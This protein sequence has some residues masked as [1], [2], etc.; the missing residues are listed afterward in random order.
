MLL[1]LATLAAAHTPDPTA[2]GLAGVP[3]TPEAAKPT[4]THKERMAAIRAGERP[5]MLVPFHYEDRGR[6]G[7]GALWH[8]GHGNVWTYAEVRAI[9]A[10]DPASATVAKRSQGLVWGGAAMGL[11]GVTTELVVI[12]LAPVVAP[13]V[14]AADLLLEG[15]GVT[16]EIIGM[17]QTY[18]VVKEYNLAHATPPEPV[19]AS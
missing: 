13:F 4:G 10:A 9:L 5:E 18:A 11:V 16:L 17:N 12:L 8:D 14:L 2:I 7:P 19:S 3:P 1:L 6:H 15:G